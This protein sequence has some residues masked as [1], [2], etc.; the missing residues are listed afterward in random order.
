MKALLK[1][2]H[3]DFMRV[4]I[5]WI[6]SGITNLALLFMRCASNPVTFRATMMTVKW[7]ARKSPS[8]PVFLLPDW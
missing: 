1:R 6:A 3:L 5:R 8:R 7:Q 2:V 4:N